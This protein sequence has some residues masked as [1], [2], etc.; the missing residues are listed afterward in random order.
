M[1]TLRIRDPTMLVSRAQT[2]QARVGIGP[3]RQGSVDRLRPLR[4]EHAAQL[5]SWQLPHNA[6]T[7]CVAVHGARCHAVLWRGIMPGF[8]ASGR[9]WLHKLDR[10]H[11]LFTDGN[12]RCWK[13]KRLASLCRRVGS[14]RG[15]G[16]G[17]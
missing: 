4:Q 10:E 15:R 12:P 14:H 13:H 16:R 6:S 3:S 8:N 9:S 7:P 5:A 1:E 17:K 2:Q 11:K